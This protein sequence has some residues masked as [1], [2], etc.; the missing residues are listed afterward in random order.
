MVYT[1]SKDEPSTE[2]LKGSKVRNSLVANGAIIEGEIENSIIFRGVTVKKEQLLKIQLYSK[3]Q[4]LVK[5]QF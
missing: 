5:V 2:Y 4:K 3:I 1:K